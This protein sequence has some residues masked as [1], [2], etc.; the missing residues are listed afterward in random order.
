MKF[1]KLF[2]KENLISIIIMALLLVGIVASG[3]IFASKLR[4]KN[5]AQEK[6]ESQIRLFNIFEKK[7]ENAPTTSWIK[8]LKQ[9]SDKLEYI[10]KVMLSELDTPATRLPKEVK[11]PLKFKEEIFKT[12]DRIKKKAASAGLKIAKEAQALGFEEYEKKIPVKE[13]VVNLTYQLRAIEELVTLMFNSGVDILENVE[14]SDSIDK[15]VGDE[16]PFSYRI[17]PIRL[18]IALSI[19]DLAKFLYNIS[20]SDYIFLVNT[21]NIDTL[22]EK[23]SQLQAELGISVVVFLTQEAKEDI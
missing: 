13:E 21:L 23:E 9:K 8:H 6:M 19:K 17:F 10:N 18:K 2:I 22:N 7:K 11:E 20:E 3:T 14:F 15:V 5:E 4:L 1:L 16:K 12:Q